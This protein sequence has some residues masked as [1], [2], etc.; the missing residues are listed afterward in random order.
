MRGNVEEDDGFKLEIHPWKTQVWSKVPK[1][2][3]SAYSLLGD[4]C[5]ISDNV[6]LCPHTMVFQA[7]IDKRLA[8]MDV[9]RDD[10]G[11][12]WIKEHELSHP[13]ETL[14]DFYDKDGTKM[15]QFY[16]QANDFGFHYCQ[17]WLKA[18]PKQKD[19]TK[20]TTG[21]RVGKARKW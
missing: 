6:N 12:L 2:L 3:E 16:I 1:E 10:Q 5:R 15:D 13:F 14:T 20:R 21:K 11:D 9:K 4:A 19:K 18:V 17:F 8:S 7:E